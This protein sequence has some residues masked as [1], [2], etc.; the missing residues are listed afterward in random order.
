M[1]VGVPRETKEGERRIAL[2]P[3]AVAEITSAGH[4]VRVET[5]A[6]AGIGMGDDAYREARAD[7]VVA[8][9]VWDS[10]LIVKVKEVQDADLA[11]M[12]RG[13]T[14]F[15]FH[16][17]PGEPERTRALAAKGA[18]AIAFEMVRD[19][20]GD[21]PLLAPMS[22]IAGRMAVERFP[23]RRV[24]VL[25]AGHAGRAAALAARRLGAE[26]VVL[27]RTARVLGDGLVTEAATA[28][29]VERHAL[30]ADLVIGA[31]FVAG[32]PTPKLLPRA[33]VRRMKPGATIVDISI[34][35]GGVAETSRPTTHAAP[36]YVDEGIV[37]YCVP[38]IPSGDPPAASAAL[39]EAALP[40][41][42]D[43]AAR[44]S[45][46]GTLRRHRELREAV[47]LWEGR[48]NHAGI[49]AEAGLPYTPLTDAV[50]AESE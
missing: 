47:L 46:A 16:H 30:Q 26:V 48:V 31:V 44:D 34:D 18:T 39:S 28:D 27:A 22:R 6:G 37:H 8:R 32:A 25:G 49:A 29:N 15:S 20:R 38:N 10:D 1:I 23:A 24:L 3:L 33:L 14:I 4:D 41:V 36:T 17:L 12:P 50:L 35:A 21:F 42:L 5:R 43:M 9:D 7:I 13:A 40:Y 19:A 45:V 11:A 2:L